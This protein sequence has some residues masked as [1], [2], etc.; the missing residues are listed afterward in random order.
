MSNNYN[1]TIEQETNKKTISDFRSELTNNCNPAAWELYC[2]ED[3]KHHFNI[4]D[5]P[6]T[7]KGITMLS[8]KIQSAFPDIS[9]DIR[10][11]IAEDD[12][13]VERVNIKAVHS[14]N[15]NEIIPTG[16]TYQWQETHI[17]RLKNGKIVEHFP[18]VRLEKIL[19]Q[20]SGQGEGFIAPQKSLL[21]SFIAVIMGGIAKLYKNENTNILSVT[22][23][24]KEVVGRYVNEFKNKQK[25]AVFPKL[26]SDKFTHHFNFPD[27]SNKMDSFV[28]VGQMFLS[29]FP[30]VKVDL[31]RILAE[32]D[33]VVEQNKVSATHSGTFNGVKATN[34]K[35]NW[36]ETHIYRLEKG[37]IIENFPA[38]NFERIL[39]Q[40]S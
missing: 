10:L 17:Y 2:S 4:P 3:L 27:R 40:I 18:E 11:L 14:G 21:S 5:V 26:F 34:K 36:T 39:L 13:V 31:Q 22:E 19:W 9:S 16:K 29:A 30:D 37:K 7:L 25:F 8:G 23:Q 12:F 32:G 28:S 15:Y 20:I 38:V 33:F 1:K 35:V 24:N 6:P